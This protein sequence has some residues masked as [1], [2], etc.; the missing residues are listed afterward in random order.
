MIRIDLKPLSVNEAWQGKRY[1]TPKYSKFER[2]LLFLL[3]KI[4]LPPPPYKVYYEFGLSNSLA[5]WDNPI[6]PAQDILQKKYGFDDRDIFEAHIRKTVVPKGKE[7]FKFK[8]EHIN[9]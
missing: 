1:K 9:K 3:P 6:K 4:Q 2:D 7:Y 5:D 8:I